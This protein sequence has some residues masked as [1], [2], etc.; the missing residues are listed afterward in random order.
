M[1]RLKKKGKIHDTVTGFNFLE[2]ESL[3]PLK[4]IRLKCRECTCDQPRAIRECLVTD[5]PL[6]PF[7]HGK[8]PRRAGLG[9]KAALPPVK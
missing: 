3:T 1:P 9:N 5:C 2:D 8:N 7:R 4:S 6:W